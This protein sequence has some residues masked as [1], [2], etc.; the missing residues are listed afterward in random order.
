MDAPKVTQCDDDSAYCDEA[1]PLVVGATE[2]SSTGAEFPIAVLWVPD[3]EQI[4]GWREYNVMP[5]K[6]A[7]P[8]QLGFRGAKCR[9]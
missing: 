3:I 2:E 8:G 5:L 7:K 4:N 6:K 1:A 9:K